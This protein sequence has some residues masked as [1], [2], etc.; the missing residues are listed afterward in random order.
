MGKEDYVSLEV[1]KL[2][3]EKGFDKECEYYIS[4]NTSQVFNKGRLKPF[5]E[6]G[7]E[8]FLCPTL[9]EAQKWLRNKKIYV[10]ALPTKDNGVMCWYYQVVN[11]N[12]PDD[13]YYRTSQDTYPNYETA[14]NEGIKYALNSFEL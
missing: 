11:D 10:S 3:K 14:L 4:A 6:E 1:A 13:I 8:V 12:D 2:L 5:K 9:Y 7:H